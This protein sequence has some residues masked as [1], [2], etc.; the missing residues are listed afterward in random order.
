MFDQK[1]REFDFSAATYSSYYFDGVSGNDDNDGKSENSP[2]KSVEKL[3]EILALKEPLKV[4]LRRGSV[5]RGKVVVGG[6]ASHKGI[7]LIVSSYGD[8][9]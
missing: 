8:G 5:F 7:P 4:F 2:F 1:P 3:N 9:A 6:M